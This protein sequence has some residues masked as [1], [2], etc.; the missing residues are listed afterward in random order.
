MKDLKEEGG[1]DAGWSLGEKKLK[2]GGERE[3]YRL[4]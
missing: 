3:N 2:V 1:Q 4:S